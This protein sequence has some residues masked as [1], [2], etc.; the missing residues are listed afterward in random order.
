MGN[1]NLIFWLLMLVGMIGCLFP[2]VSCQSE[3]Q[4]Q[5]L[6]RQRD[7]SPFISRYC[8]QDAVITNVS[9]TESE[10]QRVDECETVLPV[11]VS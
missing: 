2:L 3:S 9:T 11:A 10:R 4:N 6:L 1:N 8:G 5:T 7:F